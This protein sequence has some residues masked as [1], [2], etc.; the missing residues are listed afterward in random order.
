M[1]NDAITQENTYSTGV[2]AATIIS[3]LVLCSKL[4][5]PIINEIKLIWFVV[6]TF[7][8]TIIIEIIIITKGMLEATLFLASI[9]S[10]KLII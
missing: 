4:N 3:F 6:L 5:R 7:R 2:I 9:M 8:T 10:C 1:I